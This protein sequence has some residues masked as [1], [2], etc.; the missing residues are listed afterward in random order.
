VSLGSEILGR[1]MRLPRPQTRDV[2]CVRDL[3]TDADDGAVLLS[4][5]WVAVTASTARRRP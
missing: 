2:V 5:R 3:P 4:D 1:M